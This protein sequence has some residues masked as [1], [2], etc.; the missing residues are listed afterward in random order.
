MRRLTVLIASG[1]TALFCGYGL[2]GCSDEA[3]DGATP[4]IIDLDGFGVSDADA[5][6]DS[7]DAKGLGDILAQPDVPGFIP[8]PGFGEAC[9]GNADCETGWCVEGPGGGVCTQT[10]FEECPSN[11]FCKGVTNT[12]G[13]LTFLC[14]PKPVSAC[15]PCSTNDDCPGEDDQ[16][17]DVPPEGGHCLPRCD[18]TH[19]CPTGFQCVTGDSAASE[20]ICRPD[21]GSCICSEDLI[22]QVQPCS[23][24]SEIGTCWGFHVCLGPGGFSACDAPTPSIEQCDGIDND[25]NGQIDE[26]TDGGACSAENEF[27][28]CGG[29]WLCNDD[30]TLLC[31]APQPSVEV[32]DGVDNNCDGVT[33]ENEGDVDLDD[34]PD[35]SDPD[36]DGD[37]DP[38]ETDCDP[39]DPT[40]YTGAPE[41]CNGH[42]DDCDGAVP[43]SEV[44]ADKDTFWGCQGD[45]DDTVATVYPEAPEICDGLDNDCDGVLDPGELDG[46]ND[47]ALACDTDCDD[48][49]ADIGPL[50]DEACNFIDDDCDGLTDEVGAAGC[51]AWYVDADSDGAG[52]APALC[53]CGASD[54]HTVL[55]GGDCAPDDPAV[56]PLVGEACNDIDD[57]CDGV[58][59]E[60]GADGCIPYLFDGDQD[61]YGA[62][63]DA[64]CLCEDP[65][66]TDALIPGDC[67]DED[68]GIHPGQAEVC[69]GLD[70]NCDDILPADEIDADADGVFICAGDCED[71]EP[72]VYPGAEEICDGFDSDCDGNKPAD[73][74]DDD[75]DGWTICGGD[76][77]DNFDQANPDGTE[78]C[79][80]GD[81]DCNEGANEP[82]AEGCSLMYPD[83]DLDDFGPTSLGQCVCAPTDVLVTPYGSDCDDDDPLENP[84]TGAPCSDDSD[85]CQAIQGCVFGVCV[86]GPFPCGDDDD[87]WNDTYCLEKQCIP[88]GLGPAELSKPNCDKV[89]APGLFLPSL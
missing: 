61:G 51:E 86:D 67:N 26:G 70:T 84:G 15:L 88:F 69:D 18:S 44:D 89:L 59:D 35:C 20:T 55:V 66:N 81:E 9:E 17:V 14:V 47:G 42:D 2:S 58:T 79:G 33:D 31:T 85:C 43:A 78:V 24:S 75:K 68:A 50:V 10:C 40:V 54:T 27:G 34:I 56:S 72:L 4:D 73:E 29:N 46:D 13:D 8:E 53:L 41:Q 83:A 1:A 49:T 38:N 45:C 48:T 77:N 12:G 7:R 25:C 62:V 63:G 32:C 11:W 37:G 65:G 52:A 36:I 76:C 28:E 64:S 23:A 22:G 80:G 57:D 19:P 60:A 5:G 3:P 71:G 82:D 6:A 39:Y 87:C 74:F 21:T 16:C 30:G